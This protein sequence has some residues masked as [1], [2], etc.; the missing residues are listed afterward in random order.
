MACP[1]DAKRLAARAYLKA[2]YEVKD[3]AARRD[4]RSM[5]TRVLSMQ[6]QSR[7]KGGTA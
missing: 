7:D 5:A 6:T 2:S 1:E 4:Y 3:E